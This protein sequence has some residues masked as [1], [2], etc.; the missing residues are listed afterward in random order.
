MI[1]PF[2]PPNYVPAPSAIEGIEV[3]KPAPEKNEPV[4]EVIEFNCPRCGATTSFSVHEG[5]LTCPNCG[6]Y[7]PPKESKIGK[8]ADESE[9]TVKTMEHA[10]QVRVEGRREITCQNCGART[11]IPA[12]SLAVTCPFCGS[13]QVIM[14]EATED[15]FRPSFLVPFKVE[16]PECSTIASQW[17]GSSWM[18]PSSLKKVVSLPKFNG[19]Y[20]PFWTFDAVTNASWKAEVGHEHTERHF[21]GGKWKERIVTVWRWESGHVRLV[22]DDLIVAG[23]NRLSGLLL[24]RIRDFDLKDLAAF[25]PKF[26]AGLHAQSYDVPLEQAWD[27]SRQQMRERTKKACLNQ[28]STNEVRNFSMTV[29]FADE[30][31]RYILLPIYLITYLYAGKS[32]TVMVNGQ[33]RSIAGQRP[34]DW[35]RVW[36]VI[37]AL[38]APGLLVGL[39]GVASIAFAGIGVLIAGVGFVLFAIGLAVSIVILVQANK[40]DDA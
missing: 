21:E 34:V 22:N 6:Y 11:S 7:E 33:T 26:L 20:L 4:Q 3:Y 5:G 1:K 39:V 8:A 17:L 36:L 9:F 15:K 27:D 14:R 37:A 30:T 18:T 24:G 28:T 16:A 32:Y 29:D 2:P 35:N 10:D 12:T 25:E 23:T 31:W 13:N 19:I 38:L 40:L